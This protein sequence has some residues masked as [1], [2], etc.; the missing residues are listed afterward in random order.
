MKYFQ[1]NEKF[2]LQFDKLKRRERERGREVKKNFG[3]KRFCVK[4]K[5]KSKE[6]ASEFKVTKETLKMNRTEWRKKTT[7]CLTENL[8]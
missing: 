7:L 1:T 6:E 4:E 8:L 3:H 2:H 5:K